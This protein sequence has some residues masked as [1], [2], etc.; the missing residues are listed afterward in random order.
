[1]DTKEILDTLEPLTKSNHNFN[2]I[3]C[4]L[5]GNIELTAECKDKEQ[6]ASR[7]NRL[8]EL[9]DLATEALRNFNR[10]LYAFRDLL[11]EKASAVVHDAD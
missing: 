7:M 1:M 6:I 10:D 2:N 3:Y 11:K 5:S 8:M 4:A 9:S